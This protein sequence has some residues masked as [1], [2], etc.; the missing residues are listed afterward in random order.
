MI[1]KKSLFVKILKIKVSAWKL[2]NNAHILV[3]PDLETCPE[4]QQQGLEIHAYYLRTLIDFVNGRPV[5]RILKVLRLA[6]PCGHT[7]AVLF[8]VIIPY[9]RHSLFFI[10]RVL[11][12]YFCHLHSVE[13]LCERFQITKQRLYSWIKKWNSDK[14]TWLG[15]LEFYETS[16]LSFL[17]SLYS[18]ES[19][20]SFSAE[21]ISKTS[22]SFM[23]IHANPSTAHCA[24]RVF[25]PDYSFAYTT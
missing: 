9:E 20:S 3:I 16:S 6:C 4:C 17:K 21:F 2:V 23:Q 19:Y 5:Q 1:R 22:L 15:I 13:E 18:M 14:L 8:D 10:L 25:A 7:H 11:G 12:E 24:Q